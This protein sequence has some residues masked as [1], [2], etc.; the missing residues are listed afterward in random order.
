[1]GHARENW[2]Y[3][4]ESLIVLSAQLEELYIETNT[5]Q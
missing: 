5:E 1:V 4:L 2:N 3:L